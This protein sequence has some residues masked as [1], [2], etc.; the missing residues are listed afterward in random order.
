LRDITID[1]ASVSSRLLDNRIRPGGTSYRV[2]GWSPGRQQSQSPD[3]D[4][5]LTEFV[6]MGNQE[7]YFVMSDPSKTTRDELI[8]LDGFAGE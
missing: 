1:P 7:T 8:D 6:D 5:L 2:K 3:L 4:L